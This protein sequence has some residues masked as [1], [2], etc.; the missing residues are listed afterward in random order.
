[1]RLIIAKN[2]TDSIT[3]EDN[4]NENFI[5]TG[6]IDEEAFSNLVTWVVENYRK[7]ILSVIITSWAVTVGRTYLWID[8]SEIADRTDPICLAM[9]QVCAAAGQPL[10]MKKY[11]EEFG[12]HGL[13][14]AQILVTQE[15]FDDEKQRTMF[16]Q[17]LNR[18]LWLWIIPVIN[19][20]DPLTP[21]EIQVSDNDKLAMLVAKHVRETG[22][23]IEGLILLSNVE[24]LCD[25]HP[26]KWGKLISRVSQ[27]DESIY[28][29]VDEI[30][31][32]GGTGGMRS[33]VEVW[34][35]MLELWIPMYIVHGK[36]QGVL[37]K[38]AWGENIGTVF[39]K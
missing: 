32:E 39:A 8:K 9:R 35:K 13:K 26:K 17:N 1:M 16:L 18:L 19:A 22:Q 36:A 37:Q 27:V 34:E 25:G 20:N 33:K 28:A 3:L 12:K 21:K 23:K 31:S 5:G 24:W 15:T 11:I 29:M 6:N 2:G 10:L 7:G 38:I 14:V 4:G 30:T